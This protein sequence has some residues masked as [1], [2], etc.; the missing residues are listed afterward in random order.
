MSEKDWLEFG[1]LVELVRSH[2]VRMLE[3]KVGDC[4]VHIYYKGLTTHIE[5]REVKGAE[6]L[7]RGQV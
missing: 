3:T 2:K 4:K 5:L 6:N 1:K 7:H